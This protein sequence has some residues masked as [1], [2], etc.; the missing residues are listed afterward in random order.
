MIGRKSLMARLAAIEAKIKDALQSWNDGDGFVEALGVNLQKYQVKNP[1][2]SPGYD[3][4]R[5][6]SDTAAED[7]KDY[8]E[9]ENDNAELPG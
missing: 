5:A 7:W 2:G 9:G 4:M 1:Y 3:F 6:L 8:E